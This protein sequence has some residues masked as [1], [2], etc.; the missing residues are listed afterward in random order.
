MAEVKKTFALNVLRGLAA[1]YVVVG[2][3]RWLLWEGYTNGFKLHPEMYSMMDKIFVYGFSLFAYGHEA[4]MLFFVLSGF[5]IHYSTYNQSLKTE[6]FNIL[7][8]LGKRIKRIYPPF[9]VALLI[10]W[11][12]DRIGMNLGYTIYSQ[13]T[14]FSVINQSIHIDHSLLTLFG[15]CG[16]LQTLY[17]PVWGSNGP[18]WSLMYE[19]WFYI[20][21]IPVFFINKRHPLVTAFL[22]GLMFIASLYIS[23]ETYKWITVF[24]FFF[25]WY[26]GVIAADIYLGRL[27]GNWLRI[28]LGIC[29]AVVFG[30]ATYKMGSVYMH[31]Y[32]VAFG[33]VILLYLSLN[34]YMKLKAFKSFEWISDFSYTL[35]VIHLPMVVLMSGWLQDKYHGAL[36]MHFGYVFLGIG[37]SLLSAW[38]LHLVVEKPFVK[39]L[40]S[41][42]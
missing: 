29:I 24:N 4:V 3:C 34:Y 2:H 21:Y 14:Q 28:Q 32:Y 10:T 27:V 30:I 31:D 23:R 22:I 9:L 35:Y 11:V 16:M 33:F 25:A 19:W 15:N 41:G 40:K 20:L 39:T 36:P 38:S 13:Q 6:R 37:I 1:L 17:T 12:L 8:Y 5:V 42:K 7:S 26:L 18:L